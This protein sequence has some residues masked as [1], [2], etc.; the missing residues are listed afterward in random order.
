MKRILT[1]IAAVLMAVLISCNSDPLGGAETGDITI[2]ID[3]EDSKTLSMTGTSPSVEDTFWT[4]TFR[5]SDG[6]TEHGQVTAETRMNGTSVT[7]HVSPGTYRA[8]VW[9]YRDVACRELVYHGTGTGSVTVKGTTIIVRTETITD[10]SMARSLSA[11]KT[12][13]A[14]ADLVLMPI[15]LTGDDDGSVRKTAEWKLNGNTVE[16]GRAHV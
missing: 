6:K 1:I 4:Y 16:I 3:V 11:S 13:K 15:G 10:A 12:A 7:K 9:G 2:S 14:T 8:E 5:R